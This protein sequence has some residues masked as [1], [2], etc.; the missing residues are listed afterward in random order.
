VLGCVA[1]ATLLLQIPLGMQHGWLAPRYLTPLQPALWLGLA[2][3]PALALSPPLRRTAC[4]SL[5][6]FIAWQGWSAEWGNTFRRLPGSYIDG[7]ATRFMLAERRPDEPVIFYPR[8]MRCMAEAYHYPDEPTSRDLVPQEEV[9]RLMR[10]VQREDGVWLFISRKYALTKYAEKGLRKT[11]HQLSATHGTSFE[12]EDLQAIASKKGQGALLLHSSAGKV[13]VW[14]AK[15][16]GTHVTYVP[17]EID[18]E[19]SS[20]T[21]Q[22]RREKIAVR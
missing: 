6:L 3:F 17:V 11:M 20:D 21:L 22:A 14:Q 7:A 5:A 12:L 9:A 10:S 15:S 8:F 2:M 16:N 19:P 4:C 1:A 13:V 18:Q